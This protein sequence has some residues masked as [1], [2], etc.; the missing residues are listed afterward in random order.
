MVPTSVQQRPYHYHAS[1]AA[2]G[3][4]L[5]MSRGIQKCIAVA[6]VAMIR[7]IYIAA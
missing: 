1:S 3:A 7:G 4:P 6:G 2:S 5:L